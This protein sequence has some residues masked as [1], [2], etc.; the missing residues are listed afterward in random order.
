[1]AETVAPRPDNKRAGG[2]E[3]QLG[4]AG[5][6]APTPVNPPVYPRFKA[7]S[8]GLQGR[9]HCGSAAV[10]QRFSGGLAAVGRW[11]RKPGDMETRVSGDT[12]AEATLSAHFISPQ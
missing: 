7:A 2:L 6:R 1:M 12:P 11:N 4:W 9:L 10:Q 3:F 5:E 8:T